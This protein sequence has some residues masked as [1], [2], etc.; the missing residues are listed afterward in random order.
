MTNEL[1]GDACEK[2]RAYPAGD[3]KANLILNIGTFKTCNNSASL[4]LLTQSLYGWGKIESLETVKSI[5]AAA[6]ISSIARP[7]PLMPNDI[8]DIGIDRAATLYADAPNCLAW[9]CTHPTKYLESEVYL[10]TLSGDP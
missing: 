10:V 1:C 2:R 6:C 4:F 5:N 9:V 7:L 3:R 8:T